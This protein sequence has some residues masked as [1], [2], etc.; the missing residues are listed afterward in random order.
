MNHFQIIERNELIRALTLQ[1]RHIIFLEILRHINTEKYDPNDVTKATIGAQFMLANRV[2]EGL[3]EE[4]E[5][6]E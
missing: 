3:S 1:Q 2:L 6:E 4:L 5:I